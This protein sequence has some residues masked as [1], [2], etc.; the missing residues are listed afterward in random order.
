MGYRL[1]LN[2]DEDWGVG[3]RLRLGYGVETEHRGRSGCGV[4]IETG[5]SSLSNEDWGMGCKLRS[6]YGV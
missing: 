6:R 4:K 5:V 2:T 1:K 3:C